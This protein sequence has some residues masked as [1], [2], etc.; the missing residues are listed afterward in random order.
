MTA[1]RVTIARTAFA[2]NR[3][4]PHSFSPPAT[5]VSRRLSSAIATSR[6][7]PAKRVGGTMLL[8]K[9]DLHQ[10]GLVFPCFRYGVES[11]RIR[12]RH[13]VWGKGEV[14]TEGLGIMATDMGVQGWGL[15]DLEIVHGA[16]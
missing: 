13:P 2:R 12:D 6:A 10:D 11:P 8:V 9:A 4:R 5:W 16:D 7:R 15:C 1:A 14:E 3:R